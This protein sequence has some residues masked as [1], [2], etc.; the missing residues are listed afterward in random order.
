MATKIPKW[1]DELREREGARMY[2]GV[3]ALVDREGAEPTP[4]HGV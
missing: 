4:A 2:E 3:K 1:L